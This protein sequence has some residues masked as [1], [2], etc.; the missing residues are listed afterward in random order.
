[1]GGKEEAYLG[2]HA[3]R[4]SVKMETVQ[5]AVRPVQGEQQAANGPALTFSEFDTRHSIL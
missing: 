5:V 1:M 4:M 2:M 3:G